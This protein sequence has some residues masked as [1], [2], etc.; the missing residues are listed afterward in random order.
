MPTVGFKV[1]TLHVKVLRHSTLFTSTTAYSN[2]NL[3][4]YLLSACCVFSN[5]YNI[6]VGKPEVKI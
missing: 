6:L 4:L 5:A 2:C 1:T 3:V